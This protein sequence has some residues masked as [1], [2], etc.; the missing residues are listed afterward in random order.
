MENTLRISEVSY[1]QQRL[2]ALHK[3][4]TTLR[5]VVQIALEGA[6]DESRVQQALQQVVDRHEI[7]RTSFFE[8]DFL[9]ML[10][11]A[12]AEEGTW[13]L[14]T[15]PGQ[16][17]DIPAAVQRLLAMEG[18]D[19]LA[20]QAELIKITDSEATLLLAA[21]A[22]LVDSATWQNLVTEI[23]ANYAGEEAEGEA[24]PYTKYADWHNNVLQSGDDEAAAFWKEIRQ[25]EDILPRLPFQ[26]KN[27]APLAQQYRAQHLVTGSTY[28][29]WESKC[30]K[31]EWG[32]EEALVALWAL[33]LHKHSGA[34]KF[35][36]GKVESLRSYDE[37][38]AINGPIA[39][40]LPLSVAITK[41]DL[42]DWVEGLEEQLDDLREWQDNFQLNSPEQV[43]E[44]K[45][46]HFNWGFRFQEMDEELEDDDLTWTP[47]G[48]FGE[49]DR[50]ALSLNV[51]ALEE[52]L[53]LEVVTDA[54][55]FEADTAQFLLDAVV[56]LID[57]A[58]AKAKNTSDLLAVGQQEQTLLTETFA[59]RGTAE[60]SF[61]SPLEAFAKQ[62]AEQPEG[63]ALTHLGHSL[64][65]RELDEKANRLANFLIDTFQLGT[66]QRAAVRMERSNDMI[67]TFLAVL[68]TGASYLPV[69]FHV[70]ADRL[71]FI[72][73]DS[74]ATVLV[75]ADMYQTPDNLPAPVVGLHEMEMLVDAAD[76][77][78]PAV[79]PAADDVCYTIY[80]SGSTGTPKG[81]EVTHGNLANYLQ[82]FG[83]EYQ[84]TP[85]DQTILF[86]SV[87]FDL[88]YTALWSAL[89]YGATLHLLKEDA[90]L[91][92]NALMGQLREQPIT[93][94]KLTPSHLGLIVKDDDFATSVAQMN[95]RLVVTGGEAIQVADIETY[96][97]AAPEC[98]FVNHYGPTE[99]TI[100]TVAQTITADSLEDYK[101]F[102]VI[103]KAITNNRAYILNEANE[104]LPVGVAGE[105][106]IAGKGV[107]KGYVKRPELTAEKFMASPFVEGER[108]YKTGDLA[109]YMPNGTIQFLGRKDHQIKIRG[110]RVELGE[111]ESALVDI[112]GID[113]AAVI[114][115]RGDQ[116]DQLVGYHNGVTLD[117]GKIREALEERLPEYMVP[118]R[119][120][121]MEEFPLTGN[122]KINRKALP[123]PAEVA[124]DQGDYVA[125][126][127][128]KDIYEHPLMK[129][130]ENH[131]LY[132][133]SNRNLKQSIMDNK[134]FYLKTKLPEKDAEKEI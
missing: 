5:H 90:Y 85:Q 107:A 59:T 48:L 102:T 86:S 7:L 88:G 124:L 10:S 53:A 43:A 84:I 76:T 87:A 3:Q 118:A 63:T 82:W 18:E 116:G 114:L 127:N 58:A 78:A 54:Q 123:D 117:E 128:D 77:T 62:V 111:I 70:P 83:T 42:T 95:L 24:I 93:Y 6:C 47:Q 56:A 60:L 1:V 9:G 72:L 66:G 132:G 94:I 28:E 27:N 108:L 129:D 57:R 44:G 125:P 49:S 15:H 14:S 104:L 133:A 113:M 106:C 121:P 23:A 81:V 29:G 71:R 74:E 13:D 97:K 98:V 52:G 91:D 109:R 41:T 30:D 130:D 64:S 16:A 68:K 39:Q 25:K 37:F 79:S 11:Q 21:P 50:F 61:A 19:A 55:A 40:T 131:L 103:G 119:L 12:I 51:T 89:T 38:E 20:L 46:D 67:A 33:T 110:Y 36:L 34:D 126:T 73:E 75:Q 105:L 134:D 17:E 26:R 2:W 100:G 65:F 80:T 92:L 122:G 35:A 101:A 32:M 96:L 99:A 8:D 120:I 4:G 45:L 31:E 69:D 112:E 22:L 115:Y